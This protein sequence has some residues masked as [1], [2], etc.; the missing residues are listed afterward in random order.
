AWIALEAS[1]IAGRLAGMR[2][3]LHGLVKLPVAQPP[4]SIA[5]APIEHALT[6]LWRH[7]RD[8]TWT[9]AELL[10]D[11]GALSTLVDVAPTP[12][13]AP[14]TRGDLDDALR[15]C[16]RRCEAVLAALAGDE[17]EKKR[18]KKGRS[19]G[20][21]DAERESDFEAAE[22]EALESER[23]APKRKPRSTADE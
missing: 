8:V 20:E 18:E 14:L 15:W 17:E 2:R 9:W 12:G 6:K 3:W 11:R 1:P 19:E 23:I 16:T 10:T 21:S 4:P 7:T 22:Q 13:V 5:R